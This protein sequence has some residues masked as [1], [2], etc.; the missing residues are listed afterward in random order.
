MKI[1]KIDTYNFQNYKLK[2]V[3]GLYRNKTFNIGKFYEGEN[4]IASFIKVY[5]SGKLK[6]IKLKGRK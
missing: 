5:E 2:Q 1:L 4:L 3:Q 6:R